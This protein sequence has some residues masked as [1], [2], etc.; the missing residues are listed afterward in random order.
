V[1]PLGLGS[2]LILVNLVAL[3]VLLDL[4]GLLGLLVLSVLVAL[5]A[6]VGVVALVALVGMVDMEGNLEMDKT[7]HSYNVFDSL[8]STSFLIISLVFYAM[9]LY[10]VLFCDKKVANYLFC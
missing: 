5:V 1:D 3:V 6:L 10:S 2:P 7:L 8:A 4:L 9:S